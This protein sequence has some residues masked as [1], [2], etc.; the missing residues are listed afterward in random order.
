MP[1]EELI[2]LIQ[3]HL[4]PDLLKPIYRPLNQSNPMYGHC[5]VASEALYYLIRQLN[6]TN[7]LT[8]KPCRGKDDKGIVHWWLKNEDG[9]IL[10]VTVNQY[11]SVGVPPPYIVGKCS[12][13][14]TNTPSKRAQVVI[15]RVL[16]SRRPSSETAGPSDS[17]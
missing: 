10:D 9:N 17:T 12:G 16:E 2:K 14:L 13:F 3:L 1:I 4:T 5:Y 6:L 8:Y 7:Y 11:L 15:T